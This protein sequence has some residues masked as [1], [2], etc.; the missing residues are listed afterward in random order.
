MAE[1]Y[2]NVRGVLPIDDGGLARGRRDGDS[3]VGRIL[4]G[5]I[6]SEHPGIAEIRLYVQELDRASGECNQSIHNGDHDR[7]RNRNR[8]FREEVRQRKWQFI[9]MVS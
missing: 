4:P 1:R 8:E 6:G 9:W 7:A 3:V 5:W 2:G